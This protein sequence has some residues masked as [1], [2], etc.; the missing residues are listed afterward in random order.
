MSMTD[1]QASEGSPAQAGID[2]TA[3]VGEGLGARFPRASGDRPSG[4]DWITRL[5]MV[6]PRKRG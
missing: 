5:A 6:P 3:K 1:R 4:F 2:R